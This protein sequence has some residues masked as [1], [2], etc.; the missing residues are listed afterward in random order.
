LLSLLYYRVQDHQSRDGTTHNGP[1]HPWSPTEK[2]PYSWISWGH[3]LK[4]GS[5]L[6]DNSSLCQV[7]TQ[8]QPVQW[9]T[10]PES[11][12]PPHP[13]VKRAQG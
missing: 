7:D 12:C 3:F 2:M 8:N 6:C 10:A 9:K 5:F 11:R 4:G 1:S 13:P